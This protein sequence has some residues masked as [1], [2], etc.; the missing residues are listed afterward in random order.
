MSCQIIRTNDAPPSPATC[1]QAVKAAGLI[2]VPA[3]AD[4]LL[5]L[6]LP[7]AQI[8]CSEGSRFPA[9]TRGGTSIRAATEDLGGEYNE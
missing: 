5:L 3:S 7:L 6:R 4:P 8:S 9:Q 2:F 1:S